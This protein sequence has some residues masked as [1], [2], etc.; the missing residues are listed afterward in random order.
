MEGI[1]TYLSH[2]ILTGYKYLS[3]EK[4]GQCLNM[5]TLKIFQTKKL[6]PIK[7]LTL[8]YKENAVFLDS[9]ECIAQIMTITNLICVYQ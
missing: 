9:P 7:I 3:L 8:Q 5:D 4:L 2:L 6:Q 1:A